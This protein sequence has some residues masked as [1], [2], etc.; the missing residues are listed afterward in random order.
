MKLDQQGHSDESQDSKSAQ[1][2]IVPRSITAFFQHA[3]ETRR[4]I[5][6]PIVD[7]LAAEDAAHRHEN[8]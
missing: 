5:M 4:A 3:G 2:P 8:N 1:S 6:R 7:A